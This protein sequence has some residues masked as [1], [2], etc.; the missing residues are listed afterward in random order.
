M[1]LMF[2]MAAKESLS[3]RLRRVKTEEEDF[4]VS[5]KDVESYL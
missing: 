1:K 3:E 5:D 4:Y 2:F